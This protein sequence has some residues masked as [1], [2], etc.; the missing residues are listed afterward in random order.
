MM[1]HERPNICSITKT[2]YVFAIYICRLLSKVIL[3]LEK[4]VSL[5]ISQNDILEQ[6]YHCWNQLI[7]GEMSE[8]KTC[9]N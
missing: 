3:G 5:K 4:Q 2:I 9:L 1:S 8:D 7:N 6:Y